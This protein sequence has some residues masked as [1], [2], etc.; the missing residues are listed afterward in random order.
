V[1]EAVGTST[2]LPPALPS[3]RDAAIAAARAASEKK[4]FDVRILEVRDLIVITDYFVIASGATDRQVRTIVEEVET[5]LSAMGLRAI[6]REGE[7]EG[8][9]I[10]LDFGDLVLHVFVHEEREYYELERLWKDAPEIAWSDAAGGSATGDGSSGTNSG[11]AAGS[12]TRRRAR[13]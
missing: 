5:S 9:W 4:A 7:R 13:P 12:G 3:G 2:N 8:R 6:R 10:L 1:N 11:S